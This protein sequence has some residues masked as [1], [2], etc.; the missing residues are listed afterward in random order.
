ML[1]QNWICLVILEK[2]SNQ[3]QALL[4]SRNG[5]EEWTLGPVASFVGIFALTS[6][7]LHRTGTMTVNITWRPA[8]ASFLLQDFWQV[9][10]FARAGHQHCR[11]YQRSRNGQPR[12]WD[13]PPASMVP[14]ITDFGSTQVSLQWQ[15]VNLHVWFCIFRPKRSTIGSNIRFRFD[16]SSWVRA[17]NLLDFKVVLI[18]M[19]K[20]QRTLSTVLQ[21]CWEVSGL[22]LS[23]LEPHYTSMLGW[24]DSSCGGQHRTPKLIATTRISGKLQNHETISAKEFWRILAKFPSCWTIMI[25]S[26]LFGIH[27]LDIEVERFGSLPFP[28]TLLLI[29]IWCGWRVLSKTHGATGRCDLHRYTLGIDDLEMENWIQKQLYDFFHVDPKRWYFHSELWITPRKPCHSCWSIIADRPRAISFSGFWPRRS[30]SSPA[31]QMCLLRWINKLPS[32]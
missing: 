32:C 8:V 30:V 25:R 11:E 24:E 17:F 18:T 3:V 10:S 21:W 19:E 6:D 28:R 23:Q 1:L 12:R 4:E 2:F 9:A 29:R 13:A 20:E 7:Y 16:I 5:L 14:Y 27:L 22:D 15:L 26:Q 31:I